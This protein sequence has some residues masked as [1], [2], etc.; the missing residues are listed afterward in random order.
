LKFSSNHI[1]ALVLIAGSALRLFNFF[2][3]PLT[4]DELSAL[5]RLRFDDFSELIEKGVKVDGHPAGVHVFLY[6]W[7]KL[8]GEV[9]WVIKLPFT[10]MGIGSVYLVY[11][12]GMRWF[13]SSVGLVSA[14][15][16]AS[17][18]YFVMY[19]QIARPYISGLFFSIVMV[20][21]WTNLIEK[22]ERNLWKNTGI[23]VIFSALCAYNHHFSMLFAAMVGITGLFFIKAQFRLHYFLTGVA[24]F[25]LY[26]PHLEIL[27]TQMKIGGVE[28]WLSKPT[29][30]FPFHYVTYLF[31][32]SILMFAIA[33]LLFFISIARRKKT[34]RVPKMPFGIISI[35]WFIIPIA[36]GYIYSVYVSAVLQFSVLIFSSIFI[37]FFLFGRLKEQRFGVNL[38]LV[39]VILSLSAFSLVVERNH[40]DLFYNNIHERL[41]VDF[42]SYR[43]S[44]EKG[45]GFI[46]ENPKIGTYYKHFTGEINGL[47][48]LPSTDQNY[49]SW[50]QRIEQ[51][52]NRKDRVYYGELSSTDPIIFALLQNFYPHVVSEN[53]YF[54]GSTYVLSKE[55]KSN[56]LIS[57]FFQD[58]ATSRWTGVNDAQ[59]QKDYSDGG[60]TYTLT[61][62]N[63][64]S[65][66]FQMSLWDEINHR[67][68]FISISLEVSG[69]DSLEEVFLVGELKCGAKTL[70]WSSTEFSQFNSDITTGGAWNRIYHVLKLSDIDFP[71]SDVICK[72]YIWNKGH[73]HV[74]FRDFRVEK[75]SG[76]P[77]V[78]GLF[79]P[80]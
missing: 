70:H 40:Y 45:T 80:F 12:L 35:V 66:T 9:A 57:N 39:S 71:I 13:N 6:F 4:H 33:F 72:V 53:R 31:H 60:D 29:A 25:L 16:V 49:S 14:S 54:T 69:Q 68:D 63:E 58:Y 11:R 18:Q 26:V 17:T 61:P 22:P 38:I 51:I 76:N 73:K 77:K 55:G 43:N 28:D 47:K 36:I 67:N 52:A 24:I 15:Y 20:L 62:Q 5:F 79:E 27:F 3:I 42:E 23:Y 78:Y 64:W 32:F 48:S 1:I 59:Y 10:I 34:K 19:S 50:K 65:P 7:T 37:F 74:R 44:H 75:R 46:F 56:K 8:F 30:L 41:Y 2:E 21:A